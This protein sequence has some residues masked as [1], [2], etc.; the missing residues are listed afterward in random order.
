MTDTRTTAEL[1]DA[2]TRGITTF[3]TATEVAHGA[4]VALATLTTRIEALEAEH[5]AAEI[6]RENTDDE[7][8]AGYYDDW[9]AANDN[10]KEAMER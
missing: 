7:E 9:V 8:A 3:M 1:V 2:I 5:I 10:T 6:M 4:N